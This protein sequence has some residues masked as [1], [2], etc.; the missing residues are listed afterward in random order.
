[1]I[2]L[3]NS[4]EEEESYNG[5]KTQHPIKHFHFKAENKKTLFCFETEMDPFQFETKKD[6]L[7]F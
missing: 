3:E 2:N 7:W 1:M 5:S 6:C 4:Q